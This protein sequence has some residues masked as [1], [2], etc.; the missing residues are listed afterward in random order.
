MWKKNN[1]KFW[2]SNFIFWS[3]GI[4]SSE[5][6]KVPISLFYVSYVSFLVTSN[7]NIELLCELRSSLHLRTVLI[8][9]GVHTSVLILLGGFDSGKLYK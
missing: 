3:I 7:R 8:L 6:V 5:D 9:L 1:M 2:N 4:I